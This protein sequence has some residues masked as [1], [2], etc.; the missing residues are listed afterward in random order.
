MK[1]VSILAVTSLWLCGNA[2]AEKID[3]KKASDQNSLNRCA[4]LSYQAADKKLNET[5]GK[6]LAKV[7]PQGKPRLQKAERAWVAYRDAQ[8]DFLSRRASRACRRPSARG[9]LIVMRN[10][11]F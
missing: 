8:C 11:I 4:D 5:Y 1:R 7:S 2:Y 9:L 10:A 3:C 6:L